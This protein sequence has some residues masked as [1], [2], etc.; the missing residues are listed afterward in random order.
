MVV[1]VSDRPKPFTVDHF[2]R[3]ASEL[4]LD[5]GDAWVVE[6][7]FL[8]FLE[9]YL[10]GVPECWLL[11]PEGNSKT[12]SLA[13]LAV[14][15]LEHRPEAEI[16]WAASARD[17]AEIG[18]RQ[19]AGFV[20]RSRRLAAFLRPYNGYRRIANGLTGGRIQVFAADAG[21]GDGLIFTDAFLDELHRHRDLELYRIWAGKRLKRDGQ[22]ATISTAGEPGS[23]FEETRDLIRSSTPIVDRRPG[24]VRCRSAAVALHEYAVSPRA[25]VEDMAVV[26][27]ANPFSAITVE[28][29]A[30]KRASP[31]M[32][33]AHWRRFVCNLATRS[34]SAAITEAEWA[35]AATVE[36]IPAGEPIWLGLDVA[37]KWDTT[38]LVPLWYREHDFRLFGA[39]TILEPPRDGTSLDPHLVEAAL[40]EIH[41]RNP[42][43]TVVMDTS[44]AEQ[45]AE[46]IR[47]TLGCEVVDRAQTNQFAVM[48][49][50]RFMEAL[51]NGWLKHTGDPGLARHV[52][53]AIARVLPGG[54]SR[55]DRPS[56]R[57]HGAGQDR[58]VID[59]L[60]AAAMV[61]TTAS[62]TPPEVE[63]MVSFR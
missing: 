52:L 57:R 29:L 38:A 1:C 7:F 42:V 26:K 13:G 51:R 5:T 28:Q 17:Q 50:D 32:T 23:E 2:R 35:A 56:R 37:W 60:T 61:H 53:N 16:P 43:H 14:Y 22:V 62:A 15:L 11:V 49:F 54:D 19:A 9:D 46:W 10:A 39:A 20:R 45:L 34:E 18:Y 27:Q 33:A 3:W 4:T 48:D 41:D 55:F 47:E 58:R 63:P 31:T 12:T 40:E 30:A 25:D 6:E 36:E 59:A 24:F 44:K 21:T 8:A